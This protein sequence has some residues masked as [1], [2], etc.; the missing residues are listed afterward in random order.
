[1]QISEE[2]KTIAAL[3]TCSFLKSLKNQFCDFFNNT[4]HEM[5]D[6]TVQMAKRNGQPRIARLDFGKICLSHSP[7]NAEPRE[8]TTTS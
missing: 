4:S 1:M 5:D 2:K 7:Y 8:A 6:S 3:A